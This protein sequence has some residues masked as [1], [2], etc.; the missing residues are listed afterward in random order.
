MSSEENEGDEY[1]DEENENEG[2]EDVGLFF[3]SDLVV[4]Q[5][6]YNR[7]MFTFLTAFYQTQNDISPVGLTEDQ[8]M[9]IATR[10][11]LETYKTQERKPM[12]ELDSNI[13]KEIDVSEETKGENCVICSSDFE[14]EEKLIKLTCNHL[15]HSKCI[16]EWVK[17]KSECPICRNKVET[18]ENEPPPP[19]VNS[20]LNDVD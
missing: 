6:S 7:L 18:V 14:I 20:F 3:L 4:D 8:M 17:Y 19:I 5:D 15:F 10:E 1:H 2:D 12:I 9:E 16:S 11:S 13:H